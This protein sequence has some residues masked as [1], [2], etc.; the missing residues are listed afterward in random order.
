MTY[1]RKDSLTNHTPVEAVR[2][3]WAKA[4]RLYRQGDGGCL[5]WTGYAADG[6]MPKFRN[7]SARRASWIA[8]HGEQLTTK[9]WIV[10]T[11]ENPL[12]VNPA[13]L[14]KSDRS[15]VGKATKASL[16]YKVKMSARRRATLET[17]GGEVIQSFE[18]AQ[19]IR[20]RYEEGET[21][22]AL[23]LAFGVNPTTIHRIVGGRMWNKSHKQASPWAGLLAA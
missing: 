12:C 3:A 10:N 7:F 6:T 9:D 20:K 14:K 13:H 21:A 22:N 23:A 1:N 16:A 8:K 18:Q 4:D 15:E 19:A 11:C 17:K 5:I 2:E